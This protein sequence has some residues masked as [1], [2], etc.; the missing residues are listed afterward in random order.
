MNKD[1]AL[2]KMVTK[3]NQAIVGIPLP[4]D[5]KIKITGEE[6]KR[7]ESMDALS[8]A[9][10][11]SIILVFMVLA[12]E[13]ESLLHPFTILT[14][15]PFAIVGS[16]LIFFLLGKTLNI[17]ALIG[18]IMLVGI[19]VN[20]AILLVD[21]IL[22]IQK[23]GFSRREAIMQAGQQRIRPILMTKLTTILAMLPLT[24]GFG[25][26]TALRAPMALAVIGGLITSTIMS[27]VV[28]PWVF[29]VLDGIKD[30]FRKKKPVETEDIELK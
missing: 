29:D 9:L 11:L 15:I 24:F 26:S 27:L 4:P 13:F 3:V 14:T 5:Y 7:K 20:N 1:I 28:I 16:V 17:M 8:F 21:R 25:E 23:D 10:L 2:D 6:E 19:A 22:Q 18:V 12:A 30:R